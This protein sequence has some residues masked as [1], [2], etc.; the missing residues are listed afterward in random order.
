M[1]KSDL[2]NGMIVKLRDDSLM[3]VLD[4]R[5]VEV[6]IHLNLNNYSE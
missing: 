6:D 1:K 4:N 2:K 5:L 3:V